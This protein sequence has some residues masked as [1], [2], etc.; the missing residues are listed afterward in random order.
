MGHTRRGREGRRRRGR[1]CGND[2]LVTCVHGSRERGVG[3]RL[4]QLGVEGQPY[5]RGRVEAIARVADEGGGATVV[6]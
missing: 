5:V 1:E 4:P 3:A 2:M 6:V